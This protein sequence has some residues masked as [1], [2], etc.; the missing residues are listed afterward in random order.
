MVN[1]KQV[2]LRQGLPWR[3]SCRGHH[4]STPHTT[5]HDRHFVHMSDR[6]TLLY[7]ADIHAANH[8]LLISDETVLHAPP[9][10]AALQT[11]ITSINCL[12][13]L[14]Y[15]YQITLACWNRHNPNST[16][17]P[18][19]DDITPGVQSTTLATSTTARRLQGWDARS[20]VAVWHFAIFCTYSRR[21][22]SCR[23]CS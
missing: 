22:P 4:Y 11:D 16:M 15:Q 19:S 3:R 1:S 21:L 17:S 8:S 9:S 6:P 13:L 14:F 18:C 2:G 12:I 23:R 5:N 20:S 7:V 10:T